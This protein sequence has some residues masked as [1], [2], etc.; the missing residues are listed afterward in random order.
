MIFM[1]AFWGDRARIL[2]GGKSV[3]R[4]GAKL[5]GLLLF[6]FLL[7]GLPLLLSEK[8]G[9][10]VF[11]P[12][13]IPR[14]ALSFLGG[15]GDGSAFTLKI[16][17][18]TWDFR[19]LG[20]K[21]L[22]ASFLYTAIPGALGLGL[23]CFFGIAFR[24]RRRNALDRVSEF[25]LIIP[26][27]LLIFAIQ[28]A[29]AWISRMAGLR[30]LLSVSDGRLAIMPLLAMALFPFSFA[31][32]T[33][34]EASRRAESEEFIA[35][36]RARGI[37]ER[38]IAWRHLGAVVIPRLETDLPI[39]VAFMQG[40]LFITEKTFLVSGIARFLFD[41]AFIGGRRV[42]IR[43]I[44]QY[45]AVVLSFLGL[46]CSCAAVYLVLRLALALAR[47]ALTHE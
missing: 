43:S 2:A 22:W 1:P 39:F 9:S 30:G 16:A 42:F 46:L 40:S 17:T 15:L 12:G 6:I 31:Y 44:Y 18:N 41:S 35:C 20:P 11:A 26:D 27:F 24:G 45:N 38:T 23:G 4:A 32:R 5:L 29:A 25:A 47:K 36:A 19:D 21:F 3:L 37:P 13:N 7:A 8:E 10:F 28:N 34:S 14:A 33:A